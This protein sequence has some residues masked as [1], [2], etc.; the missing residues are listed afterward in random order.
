MRAKAEVAMP[1]YRTDAELSRLLAFA[2][3]LTPGDTIPHS[4]WCK[5]AGIR[6]DTTDMD[7]L[8]R[9]MGRLRNRLKRD[10]NQV[11]VAVPGEGYRL[12][13]DPERIGVAGDRMAGVRRRLRDVA[14]V[15]GGAD[16]AKLTEAQRATQAHHVR[17]CGAMLL[18]EET[19]R[20]RLRCAGMPKEIKAGE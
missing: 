17:V 10:R 3:T 19:D 12:A 1:P 8:Y 13:T 2:E 16:P 18:A 9:L 15:S 11:L 5:A 7:P 4:E 20:K 6:Y 14:V